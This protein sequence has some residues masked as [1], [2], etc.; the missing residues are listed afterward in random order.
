M[1]R[2]SVLGWLVVLPFAGWAWRALAGARPSP[3]AELVRRALEDSKRAHE[4]L[5]QR[6]LPAEEVRSGRQLAMMTDPTSFLG[7]KVVADPVVPRN[8]VWLIDTGSGR[9]LGRIDNLGPG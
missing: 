4:H 1:R 7:M 2:R 9:Q 5:L 8:E 6:V 3:W